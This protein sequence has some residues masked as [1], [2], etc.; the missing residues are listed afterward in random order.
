MK[1]VNLTIRFEEGYTQEDES[2]QT[3]V[4]E[5]LKANG[6]LL[7]SPAKPILLD[8]ADIVSWDIVGARSLPVV[9]E[10]LDSAIERVRQYV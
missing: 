4:A 7:L 2:L 3:L 5:T 8:H 9:I 1:R 6:Y 10:R